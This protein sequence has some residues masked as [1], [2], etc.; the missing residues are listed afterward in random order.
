MVPPSMSV[1]IKRMVPDATVHRLLN[2]GHFSYFWFC[3]VCHKQIF[4]TLFGVPQG[5]LGNVLKAENSEGYNE[6]LA[7]DTCAKKERLEEVTLD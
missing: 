3:D 2:E 1:F 6:E 4:S 7:S 5:P